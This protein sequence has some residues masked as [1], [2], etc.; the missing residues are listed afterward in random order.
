MAINADA[1]GRS[2]GPFEA[3]EVTRLKIAEFARAVDARSGAH[4]DPAIAK[5]E[6]YDDVVAPTTFAA[7]ISQ[8]H[9]FNVVTSPEVGVDFS[10]VVHASESFEYVRPIVAGDRLRPTV[11][12][13][14]VSARAGISLITTRADLV[15]ADGD[16]VVSV[17]STLAVR[18]TA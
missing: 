10:K 17:M 15:D 2:F 13:D 12:I 16:Q 1:A 11:H 5:A 8:I 4:F 9:E 3:Y 6:G 18:E 14:N 7:V